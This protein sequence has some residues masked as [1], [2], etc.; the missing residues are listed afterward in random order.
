MHCTILKT[1][2]NTQVSPPSSISKCKYVTRFLWKV[3]HKSW[4]FWHFLCVLDCQSR[5]FQAIVLSV[6]LI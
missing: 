3:S 1:Y 5:C 6:N 2:K 4:N